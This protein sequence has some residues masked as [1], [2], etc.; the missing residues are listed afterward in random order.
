MKPARFFT[1]AGTGLSATSHLNSFDRALWE[2]GID[3]CNLVKVS[4][5]L[6]A[7]AAR[8]EPCGIE[9]GTVT[10][11]VLSHADGTEGEHISAGVAW[12]WCE[13]L[14]GG[15]DFGIIAED[16]GFRDEETLRKNLAGK[17]A[18]MASSRNMEP[19]EECF[20]TKEL[21]SIPADHYGSVVAAVV[22]LP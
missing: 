10:F 21:A 11:C 4:S 6:P 7:K 2:A 8:I 16:A 17:L 3:Q 14:A 12:A 19:V 22:L 18:E 1:C 5:I 20:V 9:P 15:A 13:S